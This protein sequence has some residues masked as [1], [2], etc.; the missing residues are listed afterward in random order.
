MILLPIGQQDS[1]VRRLPWVTFALIGLCVVAFVGTLSATSEAAEEV[2]AAFEKAIGYYFAHPY[3]ELEPEFEALVTDRGGQRSL[4]LMRELGGEVSEKPASELE[5][6]AQQAELDRLTG[7]VLEAI[8]RLPYYRWGLIP[9]DV[10]LVGLIAH[11][12]MHGGLLHL[13]GNMLIL[14]LAGPFIE[15]VWGR[16]LYASFYVVSGIIAALTHAGLYADSTTPMVGASGAIAGV[17]GAFLIRHATSRI[18]FFY[19]VGILIR[20]T[21]YAPAWLMLPLWLAQQVFMGMMVDGLG[22]SGGGGV[23]YWAHVGGFVWGMAAAFGIKVTRIE[24]RF[25]AG[26]IEDKITVVDNTVIDEAYGALEDGRPEEAFHRLQEA[27]RAEPDNDDLAWA[28]WDVAAR[29]GWAAHAAPAV[30]SAI[31]RAVRR[32][33]TEQA[34]QSWFEVISQAPDRLPDPRLSLAMAEACRARGYQDWQLDG[35]RRAELAIGSGTPPALA[36][37]VARAARDSD[38]DLAR[39][40]A[41]RALAIPGLGPQEEQLARE[42]AG[43]APAVSG[44]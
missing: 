15:D 30:E 12:F 41:E 27:L 4:D 9:S 28:L 36:L 35:L 34:L 21:F 18:R 5:L 20:G 39:R 17:I 3:L 10:E 8:E 23:A 1:S 44:K 25:I 19:M 2:G 42:I 43:P 13:L 14:F 40:A 6:E 37:K 31:E 29:N 24:E 7:A 33:E 38:P 32:G 22:L 16:P 26:A 11:M